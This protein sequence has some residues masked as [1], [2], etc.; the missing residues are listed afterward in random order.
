MSFPPGEDELALHERVLRKDPVVSVDVFQT[1]MPLLLKALMSRKTCDPEDA[2]DAAIDAVLLYLEQPER[3]DRQRGR[4]SAYLVQIARNR[5][6]DRYRSKTARARREQDFADVV[7]LRDVPPNEKLERGMEAALALKRLEKYDLTERDQS[8]L[9]LIFQGERS[10]RRLAEVLGLDSLPEDEMRREVK[11]H[12]DRLMK[13]LERL[14][15]E[16]PDDES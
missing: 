3:Y 4:L 13:L 2:H 1:Y 14:G 5:A 16:G 11:R 7:E 6:V 10:T 8:A 15:K 9:G 12:R